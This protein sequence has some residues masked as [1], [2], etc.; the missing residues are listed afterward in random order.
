[1]V[2]LT[3]FLFVRAAKTGPQVM[4]EHTDKWLGQQRITSDRFWKKRQTLMLTQA[5]YGRRRNCYTI[6]SRYL[7][8]C[9]KKVTEGRELF[10]RDFQ[11]LCD[12]RIESAAYEHG[13]NA[14]NIRDALS[15]Q[16]VSLNRKV[17]ANL[18]IWEPRTFRAISALG[19]RKENQILEEGGGGRMD[20]RQVGPGVEIIDR[21]KF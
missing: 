11:S 21:G 2:F 20:Q 8:H 3:R 15:R 12:H 17:L 7:M 13:Y 4:K 18:A 10:R 19:A 6:A 5:A 16:N 1:M 14:Y 9:M